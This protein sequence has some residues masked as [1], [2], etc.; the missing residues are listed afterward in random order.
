MIIARKNAYKEDVVVVEPGS[1]LISDQCAVYSITVA[2][3]AD[4]DAIVSFSDSLE[5]DTDERVE[6][7][8]L[9]A[10]NHTIQLVYPGGK[11]LT[12]G[13][14]AISNVGSVDVSVTYE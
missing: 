6:K 9:T 10:E 7:V 4:G 12:T 1:N 3:E 13:L 11:L 5:Y 14:T 8:V 2:L